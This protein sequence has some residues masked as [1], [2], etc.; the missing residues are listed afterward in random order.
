MKGFRQLYCI[1]TYIYQEIPSL[2]L[3]SSFEKGEQQDQ[4]VHVVC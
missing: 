2:Y 1:C 3:P 4:P